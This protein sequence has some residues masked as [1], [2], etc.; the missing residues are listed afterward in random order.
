M[1]DAQ[2]TTI[3]DEMKLSEHTQG[4]DCKMK[5]E[6]GSG[7]IISEINCFLKYKRSLHDL[8]LEPDGHC[9]DI[10]S[11]VP[12]LSLVHEVHTAPGEAAEKH[13]AS[14]QIF[15]HLQPLLS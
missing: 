7:A 11:S 8:Q 14:A 15:Q 9:S 2:A 10:R 12:N 13:Y 3:I 5:P 6:C 4:L 1:K